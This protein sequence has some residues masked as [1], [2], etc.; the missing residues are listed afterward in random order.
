MAEP[1]TPP[2]TSLEERMARLE[3]MVEQMNHRLGNL[4]TRLASLENK[5]DN[6]FHWVMGIMLTTWITLAALI[7]GLSFQK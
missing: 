1:A 6:N 5:I 4:E 2:T 3:G 7:I